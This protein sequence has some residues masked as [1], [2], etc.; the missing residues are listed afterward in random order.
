MQD[1]VSM[2][3]EQTKKQVRGLFFSA[4]SLAAICLFSAL[5][6]LDRSISHA[7][8]GDSNTWPEN[9]IGY[10]VTALCAWAVF[11]ATG[12]AILLCMGSLRESDRCMDERSPTDASKH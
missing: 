3:D 6:S 7:V 11:A 4:G 1:I 2:I 12:K 9:L 5:I 10:L 8:R